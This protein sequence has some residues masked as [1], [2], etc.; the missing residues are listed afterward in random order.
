MTNKV[1]QKGSSHIVII[2][3]LVVALLGA[4]GFVFWQNFINKDPIVKEAETSKTQAQT[5]DEYAGWKTYASTRDGYYIKYPSDWLVINETTTD[6][7]YIRNFDPTSQPAEDPANH[8]NSPKGYINL[9][10]LKTEAN[11]AIFMGSTATEWYT[12]LGNSAVSM[13]PV[14]YTPDTVTNYEVNG[15]VAK[16]TKTVFTETDEDIFLIKNGSLYNI[17]LYPYDIS[18]K[19]TVKNILNSF[20]YMTDELK[21]CLETPTKQ[22]HHLTVEGCGH[23][24]SPDGNVIAE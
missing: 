12:K 13:G 22:G 19:E 9:R 21:K 6:G 20:T 14:T 18:K 2:V 5:K 1:S 16:K 4:L 24:R 8:K 3:I 7:P 17:N 23:P 15:M 10:V 11:D